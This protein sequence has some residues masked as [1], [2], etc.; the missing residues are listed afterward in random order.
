MSGF[1][2]STDAP[3]TNHQSLESIRIRYAQSQERANLRRN[4][5]RAHQ[6]RMKHLRIGM[7]AAFLV[8]VVC[9]V[10]VL[11]GG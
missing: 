6:R 7:A 9:A 4:A 10:V 8:M 2:S 11:I 3:G 5:M 1:N